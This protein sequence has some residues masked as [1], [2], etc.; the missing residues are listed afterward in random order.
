MAKEKKKQQI[1][2][3]VRTRKSRSASRD[4]SIMELSKAEALAHLA[5]F[6]QLNPNPVIEVDSAGKIVYANKAAGDALE[7]LGMDRENLTPF[8]PADIDVIFRK[9][10]KQGALSFVHEVCIK[11]RVF[12]ETIHIVPQFNVVRLYIRDI[13][14]QKQ[15]EK[16]L[17][18]SETRFRL[19][20]ETSAD[21]IFQMTPEGRI[22]YC[23]PAIRSFGYNPEQVVGE[24]FS[25]FV[26]QDDLAKAADALQRVN[27][28]ENITLFE[29]RLVRADLS[30]VICETKATP[31]IGNGHIVGI[32]GIT[33][34][35]S[36]HKR[37]EEELRKAKDE[38][39]LQV[40]ERTEELFEKSRIL[41]SFFRHTQTCLVF[42]D[43]DF[44]FI[45]VNEAYA[46]ACSRPE[47]DFEG[48]NYFVDYPS[49][50]LRAKFQQV[51]ETKQPYSV[52]KSPF[53]F[54]DHPEWG[55]TYWDLAVAPVLDTKGKVDFLV[56]SLVDVTERKLALDQ[57][58]YMKRL[59]SMLSTVNEAI[60]RIHDPDQLYHEIC[61]IT[62]EE[63]QF[64]MAWI[65]LTDPDTMKV[66]PVTSCGDTEGYLDNI[67]V[68]AADVPEGRGP[69][70]RAIREGKNMICSDMEYDPIMLPWK[71]RALKHGFRSSAA[72]PIRHGGSVIGAFTI[73]ADTPQFFT[74]EELELLTSLADNI[75]FALDTI[76]SEKMRLDAETNLRQFAEEIRDL[77][78]NAPC[79]YHSIDKDGTIVRINDTEL[80]WL[81]YTREEVLGKKKIYEFYTPGDVKRF[82]QSYPVFVENGAF[83]DLE[84][85]LLHR[86]G[87]IFSVLLSG[88]AIRDKDGNFLM[89]RSTMF[90][91]TDRKEAEQRIRVNNELLKLF[92]QK[93]SLREYLDAVCG[94]V[95]KW[96]GCRHAGFR[97]MDKNGTIPFLASIDYGPDFLRREG[98]LSLVHDQCICTRVIA[99]RPEPSDLACMTPGGSFISG[100]T[101]S[102][103]EA[104]SD[105]HRSKYRG[106]CMQAGFRSLAVVPIRYR[107]QTLGAIHIADEREGAVTLKKME[108][109]EQLAVIVGEAIYRFSADEELR[110]SREELRNL[111]KYLRE[112][113][114]NERTAIAREIHDELGQIITALRLGLAWIRDNYKDDDVIFNKSKSMLALVDATIQTIQNIIAELR[115]GILDVLGLFAAIEWQAAELKKMSGI[116]CDLALPPEDVQISADIS[117]NIFRIIQELFTNIVR[118]SNATTVSVRIE[119][120][121]DRLFLDVADNGVG[122]TPQNVSSPVSFG[123]IGIRE[124]VYAMKGDMHIAGTPGMGTSVTI[125]VPVHAKQNS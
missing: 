94:L 53:I 45:R 14:E 106:V 38:L 6:P 85:D 27:S 22:T 98:N 107:D 125:T 113:R 83:A 30:S 5:S 108:F 42:L 20:S 87:S 36:E 10:K 51:V 2:S 58:L 39:E 82:E 3:T 62:V 100:N 70:G 26:Q 65:G 117:T 61:R 118:Y 71:G 12:A 60:I 57:V 75:S 114:E 88:T 47:T 72:I 93:Y 119:I 74:D 18:I 40:K 99:G 122:I 124:R 81:G 78:N 31:V 43:R 13:S 104:L 56:F 86:D 109:I 7:R 49:E 34:D 46:K 44:N 110:K 23:S 11:D 79:G 67:T 17:R 16:A 9:L 41:G 4:P 48:H 95:R 77:Y 66:V 97:I 54:P 105:E 80:K 59:Y 103:T 50:E 29:I 33:R 69:T 90:D 84:L 55:T 91:I 112:A 24:S 92:A 96:S 64:K 76:S 8:L 63:G 32:Q 35:I 116:T 73:Y 25:K 1:N 121:G 21:I 15:T 28:G 37:V 102:F 115:P 19:I 68:Y 123:I 89:S 111:S 101:Q 52:F 120:K